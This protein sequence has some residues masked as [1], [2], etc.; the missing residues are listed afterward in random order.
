MVSGVLNGDALDKDAVTWCKRIT[1]GKVTTVV[2][3]PQVFLKAGFTLD[4][5]KKPHA[6][7]YI[8]LE[9]TSA[10]K[11]QAGIFELSGK[12]LAI[13][14]SAPGLPRPDDFSS[15]SGDGRSYTTWRLAK[16]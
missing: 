3:G 16:K 1:R 6:I 7:D 14:M 8:N 2:A 13:C 5:S 12:T 11:S 9:G 15:K 4:H 10:G